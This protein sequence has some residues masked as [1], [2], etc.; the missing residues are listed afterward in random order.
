MVG[1]KILPGFFPS[2]QCGERMPNMLHQYLI[3]WMKMMTKR[4]KPTIPK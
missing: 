4:K 1:A 2:S 3:S